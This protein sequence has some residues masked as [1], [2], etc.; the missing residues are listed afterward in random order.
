MH[1]PSHPAGSVPGAPDAAVGPADRFRYDVFVSYSKTDAEWTWNWLLPRLKAAGLIVCID[2]ESFEPGA[3]V[4]SEIER[5]VR[6]SCHTLAIL[7][8]AWVASEWAG[9]ESLLVNRQD[10][11][12]RW[13]RLIP[14]LLEPCQP[15]D[16]IQLLHWIDLSA[17]D[18]REVQL[19]R[20]VAA[21]QGRDALRSCVWMPF[22]SRVDVGGSCVGM[23][24]PVSLRC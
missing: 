16:R 20:V 17:E 24:S 1:S 12:A 5:A 7:S 18:A 8:P 4:A 13:R 19:Q 9:F 15:P 23:R 2:E 14:L 6:E 11:N 21:I 3:P 10:P 22:R